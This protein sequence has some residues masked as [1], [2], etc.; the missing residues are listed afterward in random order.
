MS[1]PTVSHW[2][3]VEH[4]LCYLK[5]SP[6]RGIWYTKQGH[7]IIEFFSNMD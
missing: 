2:A 3:I 5:E 4:I 7:T 1:S 6:I